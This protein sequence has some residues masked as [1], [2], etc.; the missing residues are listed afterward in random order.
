ME[1]CLFPAR[2]GIFDFDVIMYKVIFPICTLTW[3]VTKNVSRQGERIN[4][5]NESTKNT[6]VLL[7]LWSTDDNIPVLLIPFIVSLI[8][9]KTKLISPSAKINQVLLTDHYFSRTK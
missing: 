7:L 1:S 8:T 9:V 2:V 6:Q 3:R 4:R 5:K